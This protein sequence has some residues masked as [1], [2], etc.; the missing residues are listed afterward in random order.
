MDNNSDHATAPR[1][2]QV[3]VMRHDLGMRKG[4]QIAQ[5]AHAAMVFLTQKLRQN[6]HVALDDLTLA[7]RTWIEGS[8]AK[9]C[10]RV[11]SEEQLLAIEQ[12]AR[13]AGLEVHVIT[14]SGRTEFHGVPTRTCL[15]IGPDEVSA[16]DA[17][18]GALT[19]L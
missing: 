4:K 7:Q 12:R 3:I 5:G 15:A 8:F 9:V 1:Y 16:I 13:D 11:D 10:V 6:G 2:K 14:D 17:I 19:L 18:T